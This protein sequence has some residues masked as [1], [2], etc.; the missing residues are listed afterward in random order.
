MNATAPPPA[1]ASP[2]LA[3]FLHGSGRRA[4]LFAELQCGDP[5]RGDAAALAILPATVLALADLPMAQWPRRFWADLLAGPLRRDPGPAHWPEGFAGFAG[6]GAGSR[7]ALLL[8][9]VAGLGEA[10]AAAA[11]GVGV[12]AWQL[13]LQ[14]AAPHDPA[15]ALDTDTWRRWEAEVRDALRG[16][17]PARL[18]AWALACERALSAAAVAVPA[19]PAAPFAT[20]RDVPRARRPR[21]A[22]PAL[23]L[24]V[25]GLAATF[26]WPLDR[27]GGRGDDAPSDPASPVARSPLPAAGA[28]ATY[29]PGEE[30]NLLLH[31]DFE[32]LAGGG[33]SPLLRDLA[34]SAW[35]A[36]QADGATAAGDADATD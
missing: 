15:G 17:A 2:A 11:L 25:L 31:P 1:G 27:A 33:D 29:D 16:L 9:L 22:W 20:R 13:A 7:A 21:W 28:P 5:Q 19:A 18:D 4:L 30:A 6:L 34:F 8:W 36:A 32:L 35:Y 24:C 12:P 10:D 26:L 3:A 14:R 23:A